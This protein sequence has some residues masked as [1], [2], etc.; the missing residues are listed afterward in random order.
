M[1][2]KMKSLILS[3]AHINDYDFLINLLEND[4]FFIICA[5][6][7]YKHIEKLNITPDLVIGDFDSFQKEKIN[8]REII[9]LPVEKDDTDTFFAVKEAMRRGCSEIYIAGGIGSRLDHTF[10]NIETLLYIKNNGGEGYLIN[11]NNKAFVLSNDSIKLKKE[12]KYIS[13]FSLLPISKGITLKGMKYSLENFDL[14]S[15]SILGTSNE[16]INEFCEIIVTDGCLLV[17][18]SED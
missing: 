15:D 5:D 11:E 10:A 1:A 16:I 2:N 7:G 18:L 9:T 14:R 17:I 13:L 6:G 3:A 4:D 8:C 12:K